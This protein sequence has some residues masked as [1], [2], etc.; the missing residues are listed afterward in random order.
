M[1]LDMSFGFDR[2]MNYEEEVYL[3]SLVGRK[4]SRRLTAATATQYLDIIIKYVLLASPK[5]TTL[6][7]ASSDRAEALNHCFEISIS[8]HLSHA[9]SS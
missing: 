3:E 1:M 2:D 7:V 5:C 4:S 6:Q 8:C 9:T